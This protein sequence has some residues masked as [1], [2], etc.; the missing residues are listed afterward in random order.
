MADPQTLSKN[1]N[2][3]A[4]FS[5]RLSPV[6][7]KELRQGL[8]GRYFITIFLVLQGLLLLVLTSQL[9]SVEQGT[10][11]AE[12][13]SGAFWSFVAVPIGLLMPLSGFG[14]LLNERKAGTLELLQMSRLNSRGIVTGKWLA[15]VAQMLLLITAVF[16]W[17]VLRYMLGGVDVI[18]ELI[19]LVLLT[20]G[21]VFLAGAAV[22]LSATSSRILRTVLVLGTVFGMQILGGFFLAFAWGGLGRGTGSWGFAEWCLLL[23]VLGVAAFIVMEH[24]AAQIAPPVESHAFT[25]RLLGWVGLL[26]AV[27]AHLLGSSFFPV[28]LVLGGGI[29]GLICFAAIVEPLRPHPGSYRSLAPFGL[30]GRILGFLFFSGWPSGI[31]YLLG[32]VGLFWLLLGRLPALKDE[33]VWLALTLVPAA[34]I[35]PAA[36]VHLLTQN[37]THPSAAR[38][39]FVGFQIGSVFLAIAVSIVG[40]FGNGLLRLFSFLPTTVIIHVVTDQIDKHDFGFFRGMTIGTMLVALLVLLGLSIPA[41]GRI[42]RTIHNR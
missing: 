11:V 14:A 23:S 3:P 8:R 28:F 20:A 25:V 4:E 6:L 41:W 13:A 32:S 22:G 30:S 7:V 34:Y 18:R 10:Y 17:A 37:N 2:A 38:Q 31:I 5:D 26:P 42:F 35:V 1:P 33:R 39:L 29:L 19:F 40:A 27:I 12:V 36:I 15:L 16:P 21:S 9:A 24:G